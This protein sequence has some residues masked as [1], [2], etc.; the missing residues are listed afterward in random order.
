MPCHES[1]FINVY[2]LMSPQKCKVIRAF[3]MQAC[4]QAGLRA[5]SPPP[6]LHSMLTDRWWLAVS[7]DGED[8]LH[9]GT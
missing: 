5:D 3:D 9:K 4:S 6:A 8:E 1:S 2:R 7:F